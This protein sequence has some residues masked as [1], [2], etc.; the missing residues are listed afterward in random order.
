MQKKKSWK[1]MV[2]R[3]RGGDKRDRTADL[4]NAMA[5][6]IQNAIDNPQI[7]LKNKKY[8]KYCTQLLDWNPMIPMTDNLIQVRIQVWIQVR[9]SVL[10]RVICIEWTNI[11]FCGCSTFPGVF[12][13]FGLKWF[14]ALA[15][16]A[17]QSR[18]DTMAAPK[19]RRTDYG[20]Q[21]YPYSA[22]VVI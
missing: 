22:Y 12:L 7:N 5:H 2:F 21:L 6:V 20:Y 14:A 19:L 3:T 4:L 8:W 16:S 17:F 15:Q 10:M 9:L 18:S 1:T 13:A 11:R